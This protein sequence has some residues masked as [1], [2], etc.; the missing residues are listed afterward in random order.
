MGTDCIQNCQRMFTKENIEEI[1]TDTKIKNLEKKVRFSEMD[2][3]V[4]YRGKDYS[5][6]SPNLL[7]NNFKKKKSILKNSSYK[8]NKSKQYSPKSDIN[9]NNDSLNEKKF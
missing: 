8:N 4:Y 5:N 7:D 6:S 2:V 9:N 3:K 1:K